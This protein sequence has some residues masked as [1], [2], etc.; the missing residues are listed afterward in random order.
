M[1]DLWDLFANFMILWSDSCGY[2]GFFNQIIFTSYL[3]KA[4]SSVGGYYRIK[5]IMLVS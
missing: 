3:S 4:E 1:V 5:Y 2:H